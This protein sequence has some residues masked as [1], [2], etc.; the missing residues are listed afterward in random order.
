[1]F[2]MKTVL[3]AV[4]TQLTLSPARPEAERVRRRAITLTPS[5]GAQV[6]AA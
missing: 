1:M 2:E 5:A 6:V 3:Q 4:A